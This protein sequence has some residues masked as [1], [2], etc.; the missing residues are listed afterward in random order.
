MMNP[1]IQ[2]QHKLK[3]ESKLEGIFIPHG[4][5]HLGEYLLEHDEVLRFL[6]GFSGSAGWLVVTAD[7]AALFVDSRYTLQAKEQC[8]GQGLAVLD[9]GFQN[10]KAWIQ[11]RVGKVPLGV[12]P[13]ILSFQLWEQLQ[14]A[15]ISLASI[16][17]EFYT[18]SWDNRPAAPCSPFQ[19]YDERYAG[20]SFSKKLQDVQQTLKDQGV[21]G[22]PGTDPHEIAW[23]LNVRGKDLS[24]TP[25]N[26]CFCWIPAEGKPSLYAH[27]KPQEVDVEVFPYEAFY[28]DCQQQWSLEKV[29]LPTEAP[30]ALHLIFKEKV[31][32]KSPLS[33][34]KAM[35]N[36]IEIQGSQEAHQKDGIALC[37]H[38]AWLQEKL[39]DGEEVSE[40]DSAH[41]LQFLRAQQSGYWG[42]SFPA[43]S[44]MGPHGAIVHYRVDKGSDI[45]LS[46]EGLY[47]LDSG[48]QY[49]GGTTDVTRTL[50]FGTPTRKQIE[51]YT[52]VLKGLIRLSQVRFP[53]GTT[54]G[55]LDALA[56]EALWQLGLDYGHGT[57]HGVGNFL[58]VHEGP[59]SISPRSRE[60]LLPGMILSVEP[61]VYLEGQFGIRLENLVLVIEKQEGFCEFE[62][63]TLAPFQKKLIDFGVL[64]DQEKIWF[65][66]YQ[67]N[68]VKLLSPDLSPQAKT[69][70]LEG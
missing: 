24:F 36:E 13:K 17:E 23:L 16:P 37:K 44:G 4:D 6:T 57:G 63:L 12:N 11:K 31:S 47:L 7:Q 64:T 15:G 43:I 46:K 45:P 54:G 3:E 62:T 14:K 32:G 30:A 58:G 50:C 69:Y 59:A 5:M 26:H 8:Q 56:R 65:E 9:M 49:L 60:P 48:G 10:L 41:H 33:L 52:A 27:H 67:K 21:A 40:L 42:E 20:R 51:A 35:K 22:Y 2:L 38:F 55:Q 34:P 1:L 61:G 18:D 29:L 68:L 39:D 53:K 66:S 25:I 28:E 70:M 19:N